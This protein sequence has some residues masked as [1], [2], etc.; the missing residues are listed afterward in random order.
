MHFKEN[1][2]EEDMEDSEELNDII[3]TDYTEKP[4]DYDRRN[5]LHQMW[6]EQQDAAGTDNLLQK[7][8]IGSKPDEDIFLGE[9][10]EV[11]EDEED[12]NHEDAEPKNSARMNS[13]RAKELITKMFVDKDDLFLSDEDEEIEKIR[14]KQQLI[15]RAV[16]L[17]FI[18][19]SHSLNSEMIKT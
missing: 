9:E 13:K 3:A 12:Y 5:E 1:E 18:V 2:E 11:D 4:V 14:V 17:F 7:L 10:Q 19:L 8:N 15:I 6:L 16:S